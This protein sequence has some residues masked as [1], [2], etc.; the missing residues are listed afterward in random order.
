MASSSLTARVCAAGGW[1]ALGVAVLLTA[2]YVRQDLRALADD[3][4]YWTVTGPPC[5]QVTAADIAR[6]SRKLAQTFTFEH[7]QFWRISGAASC[8]GLTT[9]GAG[10]KHYDVCQFNAPRALAAGE[11]A[12]IVFYDVGDSPATVRVGPQSQVTC[13]LSARFHP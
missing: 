1:I 5:R 7:R 8:S 10:A 9:T 4:A 13:V 3:R 11:G 6:L 2:G 12:H